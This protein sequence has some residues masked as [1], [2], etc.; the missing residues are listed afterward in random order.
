MNGHTHNAWANNWQSASYRFGKS[1]IYNGKPVVQEKVLSDLR[2]TGGGIAYLLK[3][4]PPQGKLIKL[5]CH[6]PI[7]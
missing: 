1:S 4:S 3:F 7:G 6:R 5:S 2:S